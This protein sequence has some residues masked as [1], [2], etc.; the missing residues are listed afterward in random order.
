[1]QE[2]LYDFHTHILPGMDDG[3]QD[4]K[5]AV[6]A[7]EQSYAQGVRYLIATPHYYH[8]ETVDKFLS[9]RQKAFDLLQEEMVRHGGPLPQI[10]LGAEVAY[11]P[12]IQMSDELP[13]LC[14]G[15][16]P[17]LLLEMPFRTWDP[18]VLRTVQNI[19]SN[20]EVIPVL[21]HIERYLPLQER[22]LAQQVLELDLRLQMNAEFI[23]ERRTRRHAKKLLKNQP[24][25]LFGTDC[26]NMEDR[27]PL[28]GAALDLLTGA[29]MDAAIRDALVLSEEIWELATK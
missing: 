16:S 14:L 11:Y 7:L 5:T 20:G 18:E 19:C 12:D 22:A 1:M 2:N 4:A 21:A 29:G 13:K 26:H 6:K 17:Y 8:E 10:C 9:R 3:F 24:P 27:Q 25:Y 28:L 15:N 23:L